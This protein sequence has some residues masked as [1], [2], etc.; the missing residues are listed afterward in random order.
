[1]RKFIVFYHTN[2][3]GKLS[4]AMG[5]D[6]VLPIDGRLGNARAFTEARAQANRLHSVKPG[7]LGFELRAGSFGNSSSISPIYPLSAD[8]RLAF[9]EA[10][11]KGVV[12]W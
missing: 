4:P 5:S 3:A 12:A 2:L 1:M 7:L 11:K 9:A 6:G 8:T 10:K